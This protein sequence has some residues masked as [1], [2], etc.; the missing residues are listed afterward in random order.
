[1]AF[2]SGFYRSLGKAAAISIVAAASYAAIPEIK[3]DEGRVLTPYYDM[4]GILTDCDG[5]TKDVKIGNFRSDVECD[6]I[7]SENA[8]DFGNNVADHLQIIVPQKTF[9][10]HVRFSY[11]I[12]KNAYN[13]ST[14]L[15]LTNRGD[16]AGGCEA[17]MKFICYKPTLDDTTPRVKI[18]GQPCYSK[19]HD[20]A[21]SNGLKLRRQREK[22]QCLQGLENA[23]EVNQH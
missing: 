23:E 21:V 17:M 22:K 18:Q 16:I 7:T 5:N 10:S 3:K 8:L 6:K 19:N 2:T 13:S 11:N 1:M 12:G 14:T 9:T 4:A 20:H 15:K